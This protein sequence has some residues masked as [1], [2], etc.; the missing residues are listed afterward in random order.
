MILLRHFISS[1]SL[2]QLLS[3]FYKGLLKEHKLTFSS[4]RNNIQMLLIAHYKA[5]KLIFDFN[6][7]I[8]YTQLSF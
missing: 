2:D 1:L 4:F 6:N 8:V 7:I 5:L 3:A